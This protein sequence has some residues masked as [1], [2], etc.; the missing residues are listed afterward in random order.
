MGVFLIV[1]EID[2]ISNSDVI[3]YS[4]I[5]NQTNKLLI[6]NFSAK[7]RSKSILIPNLACFEAIL[8]C[9]DQLSKQQ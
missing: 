4:K 9:T 3:Y 6:V 2:V 7:S 1:S 5:L 8:D